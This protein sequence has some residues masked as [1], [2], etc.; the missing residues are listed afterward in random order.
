MYHVFSTAWDQQVIIGKNVTILH[1][2]TLGRKN[3][4]FPII[5]DNVYI[6]P[7][8]CVLGGIKIGKNSVIG[9]NA[10][11]TKDVPENAVVVGNP[12]KIV[13][14]N[15]SSSSLVNIWKFENE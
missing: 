3:D 9:A 7:G 13:S 12:S 6:G 8:A 10:V 2:V 5:F 14:Y 15:G 11:V 1:N 4:S